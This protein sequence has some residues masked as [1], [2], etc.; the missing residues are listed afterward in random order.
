MKKPAARKFTNFGKQENTGITDVAGWNN[1]DER[2]FRRSNLYL[3]L[4]IVILF[5]FACSKCVVLA[6]HRARDHP[7]SFELFCSIA[8]MVTFSVSC[9]TIQVELE[10]KYNSVWSNDVA[11]LHYWRS[12]SATWFRF[13][14]CT[15]SLYF[16]DKLF[17]F[18]FAGG[19]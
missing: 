2:R 5:L 1:S 15:C 13:I 16:L 9:S 18:C 4:G 10:V 6:V 12:Q 7:S 11:Q 14:L 19:R 8:V 17:L 3:S